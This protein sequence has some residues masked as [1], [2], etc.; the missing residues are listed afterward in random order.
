MC[1]LV[2]AICGGLIGSVALATLSM[3]KTGASDLLPP[4]G[5]VDGWGHAE[6]VNLYSPDNLYE[7]INGAAD[8]YLVFDFMVLAHAGYRHPEREGQYITV[9][10]YEMASPEDAFGIY[11]VERAPD[12]HIV[13]LGDQGYKAPSFLAFQQERFYV[14]L[15]AHP[16]GVDTDGALLALAQEV[17]RRAP[18]G[19]G[20][21]QMLHVFP[22]AWLVQN[23]VR[24]VRG[25]L[26]GHGFLPRGY[27]ADYQDDGELVRLVA[28]DWPR[29]EDA[30]ENMT[31]LQ[32][33]FDKVGQRVQLFDE[34]GDAAYVTK[35]R[36]LGNI[37]V[38]R[39]GRLMAAIAGY[40]NQSWAVNLAQ[41][42]LARW[43]AQSRD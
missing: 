24:Y 31:K 42:L 13:N 26:L 16:V 20:K 41:K 5:A 4:S 28:I 1:V 6:P 9:D 15:E 29:T 43:E 12:P 33:Y 8:G 19:S 38:L 25:A 18:P 37:T 7:Y 36:Y 39:Q 35:D 17:S 3:A 40:Q 32:K 21:P 10:V 34:L 2:F 27:V 11:S 14:L 30:S 22:E 23:S